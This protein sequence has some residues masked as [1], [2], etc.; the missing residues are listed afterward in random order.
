MASGEEYRHP[1]IGMIR[2]SWPRPGNPDGIRVGP[3]HF[4][5]K[6]LDKRQYRCFKEHSV[7]P[8]QGRCR[9]VEQ[10]GSSLGS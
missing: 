6:L 9:G 1:A 2:M 7:L 10:S 8:R 4:V 3:A 5:E